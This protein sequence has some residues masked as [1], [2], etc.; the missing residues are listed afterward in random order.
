[1]SRLLLILH[2]L[3]NYL[4]S[5]C[6]GCSPTSGPVAQAWKHSD[7]FFPKSDESTHF[8]IHK[9]IKIWRFPVTVLFNILKFSVRDF[10]WF[11]NGWYFFRIVTVFKRSLHTFTM[12]LKFFFWR[13]LKTPSWCSILHA[14]R[15]GK[16]Q[17]QKNWD[18]NLCIDV[19][20]VF[21]LNNLSWSTPCCR[22]WSL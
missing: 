5:A 19:P 2:E 8:K 3:K 15:D 17:A 10:L 12:Y 22:G 21:P 11:Q 13:T 18:I 20:N 1:M 14:I 7:F 4:F 6:D 9:N 16:Q